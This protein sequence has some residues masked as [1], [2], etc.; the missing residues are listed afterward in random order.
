VGNDCLDDL[1]KDGRL[2]VKF[3]LGRLTVD[4]IGSRCCSVADVS[5][6]GVTSCG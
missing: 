6:R 5:M 4:G 1:E 3:V 2:K